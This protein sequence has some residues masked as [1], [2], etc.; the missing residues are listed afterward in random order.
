MSILIERRI[1]WA[2]AW[3]SGGGY[4]CD[5][6]RHS[7]KMQPPADSGRPAIRKRSKR[8]S[9][10]TLLAVSSHTAPYVISSR[11]RSMNCDPC[12]VDM[13]T[14]AT[15]RAKTL[16]SIADCKELCHPYV[17][18]GTHGSGYRLSTQKASEAS[19]C[20]INPSDSQRRAAGHHL[21]HFGLLPV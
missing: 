6:G 9:Q 4:R 18:G 3:N 13:R 14:L 15:A 17:A 11:E 20:P 10:G 12:S 8:P 21:M 1:L 19:P 16:V 5:L 2:F 7:R